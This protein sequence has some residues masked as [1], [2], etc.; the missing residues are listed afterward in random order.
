MRT[1]AGPK[2]QIQISYDGGAGFHLKRLSTPSGTQTRGRGGFAGARGGS[3][4]DSTR[5]LDRRTAVAACRGALG[6]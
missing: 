4:E 5:W 3:R 6:A 1:G 2:G